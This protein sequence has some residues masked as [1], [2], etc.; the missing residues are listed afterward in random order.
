MKKKENAKKSKL[1]TITM[2]IPSDLLE[3]V[4]EKAKEIGITRT[5]LF[6]ISVNEYL[7]QQE[8][9]AQLPSILEELKKLQDTETKKKPKQS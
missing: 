2:N 4:G 6:I 3:K 8:T 1:T 5:S 7:K 9:I